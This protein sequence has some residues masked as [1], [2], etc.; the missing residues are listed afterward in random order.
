MSMRALIGMVEALETLGNCK[1][2]S[3]R[4][5]GIDRR[6]GPPLV[7]RLEVDDR[8]YISVGAGSAAVD[9]RTALPNT[10]GAGFLAGGVK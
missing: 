7:L 1:A 9:A 3:F 8:S 2:L 10:D 6:T 5:S 4:R